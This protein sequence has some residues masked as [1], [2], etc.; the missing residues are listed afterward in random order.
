MEIMQKVISK[1][2]KLFHNSKK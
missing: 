1:T 2:R